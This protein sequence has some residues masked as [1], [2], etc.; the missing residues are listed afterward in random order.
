MC[1]SPHQHHPQIGRPNC[2]SSIFWHT[3]RRYSAAA[4]W[5]D[6][7]KRGLSIND[8][9]MEREKSCH[10]Q[11]IQAPPAAP[12]PPPS[13]S[14]HS[15]DSSNN[16]ISKNKNDVNPN[17][18]ALCDSM[19]FR[20]EQARWR[21]M[22]P[23]VLIMVVAVLASATNDDD[24]GSNVGMSSLA[25]TL[26]YVLVCACSDGWWCDWWLTGSKPNQSTP[27]THHHARSYCI[28]SKHHTSKIRFCELRRRDSQVSVHWIHIMYVYGSEQAES[29][30]ESRSA[31]NA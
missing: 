24:D 19:C 27:L 14:P 8:D 25:N 1:A 3:E 18:D 22:G 9:A 20:W 30:R 10:R 17:P 26:L 7:R 13:P 21:R 4:C 15:S 6:V 16:R 5:E 31:R 12:V 28:L 2:C 11:P 29:E 23:R